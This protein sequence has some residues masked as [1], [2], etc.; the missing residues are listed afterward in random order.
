M[1]ILKVMHLEHRRFKKEI[2]LFSSILSIPWRT[3]I[4]IFP[5][6]LTIQE[7]LIWINKICV[8]F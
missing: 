3:R 6:I 7:V 5:S 2:V 4:L 8:N 1:S